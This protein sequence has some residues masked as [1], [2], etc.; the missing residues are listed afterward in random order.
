M[1]Y[2]LTYALFI[3]CTTSSEAV[4]FRC[5]YKFVGS[6]WYKYHETPL[7][8]QY[9]R[10]MCLHEGG[11]LASPLFAH[12]KSEMKSLMRSTDIFTGIQNYYTVEGAPLSI[13]RHVWAPMQPNS[14]NDTEQC[15]SMNVNGELSHVKCEEPRP[16]LCYRMDSEADV[17]DCGTLDPD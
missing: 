15:L 12:I 16:Y 8:W 14:K 3:V 5:D 6:R 4:K 11:V 9:A 17:N 2:S 1:K 10:M 7:P 13:I